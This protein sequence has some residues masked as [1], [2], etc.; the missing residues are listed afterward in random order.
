MVAFTAEILLRACAH[1]DRPRDFLRDPWNLFDLAVVASALLPFARENG[2]SSS[3]SSSV[4]SSA[5][6]TRPARGNG[7]RR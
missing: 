3:T 7:K 6:S 4:S 5:P 1:A 2:S